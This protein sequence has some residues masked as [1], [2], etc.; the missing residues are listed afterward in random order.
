M[1]DT[2]IVEM[3]QAFIQHL[4]QDENV[5]QKPTTPFTNL[6]HIDNKLK[7]KVD[8]IWAPLISKQMVEIFR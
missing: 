4:N 8:F 2:R 1:G 5:S 3:Y 6:T 7:I